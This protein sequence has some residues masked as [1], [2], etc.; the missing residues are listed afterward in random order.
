VHTTRQRLTA[1]GG[2][3]FTLEHDART[4]FPLSGD[5]GVKIRTVAGAIR[6]EGRLDL[7][8]WEVDPAWDGK[9][10]R[11]AAQA[12]RPARSGDISYELKIKTGHKV[13][14]TGHKVCVRLVAVEGEML[15]IE[16]NV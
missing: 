10:F 14:Q 5:R 1:S 9:I 13:P 3:P 11:S 2:E 7:D 15:Q 12:Q 4:P 16:L 8:Y 6:V